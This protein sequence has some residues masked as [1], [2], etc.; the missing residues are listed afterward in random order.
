[1]LQPVCFS[2]CQ[3]EMLNA[4]AII[5]KLLKREILQPILVFHLDL[6]D[7]AL[8]NVFV[9]NVISINKFQI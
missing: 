4:E 2:E 6:Y 7:F 5:E 8:F 1:M 3:T 9:S